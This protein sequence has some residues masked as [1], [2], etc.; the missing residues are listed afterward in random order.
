MT[1]SVKKQPTYIVLG[2]GG[3]TAE[4]CKINEC[5]L[6]NQQRQNLYSPLKFLVAN[7]DTTSKEKLKTTMQQIG[8]KIDESKDF[9]EI[10]RSREVGQSYISSI[11]TTLWSF[12]CCFQMVWR[13][14]PRLVL[15]NGPGTCVPICLAAFLLRLVGRLSKHS[16]IV[17]V[18]SMCRVK[19]ISLSGK[20][21]IYFADLVVVQW[22][23]LAIAYSNKKNVKYF[24]R[25]M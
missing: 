14:C 21:L 15:C 19:S 1:K 17:F 23:Q 6:K 25:L 8:Y 11:F 7:S 9:I 18:E 5:I 13:D 20:I 3:H 22:P 12:L 10:P 24:G 16:K 4:M 2:S